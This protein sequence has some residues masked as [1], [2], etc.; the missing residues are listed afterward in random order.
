ML[1]QQQQQEEDISLWLRAR[2]TGQAAAS[3]ACVS[4]QLHSCGED[5][6]G[7]QLQLGD[8]VWWGGRHWP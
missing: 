2:H 3:V 7:S 8:Q 6:G 5:P 1:Q 4:L